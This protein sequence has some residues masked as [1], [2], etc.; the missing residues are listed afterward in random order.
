MLGSQISLMGKLSIIQQ[1]NN[2]QVINTQYTIRHRNQVLYILFGL[3]LYTENY[4]LYY[5]VKVCM[6]FFVTSLILLDEIC[7]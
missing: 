5:N 7:I 1:K 4:L 3:D 2:F 6:T